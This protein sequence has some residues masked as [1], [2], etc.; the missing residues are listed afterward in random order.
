MKAFSKSFTQQEPLPEASILRAT[1]IMRNGRLH[2]YNVMPGEVSETS[3]LEQEFARYQ[4]VQYCLACAS[5]GYAM[6]TALRAFGIEA[7]EPILTNAWTLSPVPGAID[8]AGGRPVLVETT[9]QLVLNLED[10]ENKL[11]GTSSRLLLLSHMRGHVVD[12][13]ALVEIL[14]R[15][16]AAL[17]E[18]CAHTM[19][20][21]WNSKKIGTFGVAACFSTQTYKHIN[22]GEGGLL[23]TNDPELM[24]R[25]VMLSGS[26]ML[27]G[28]HLAGPSEQ[29][30]SSIRLTT[31]NCSGRMDNLR[32]AIL[33]PQLADLDKQVARWLER[34][35]AIEIEL[36]GVKG[37]SV[38]ARPHK[39]H[40]V[41][42]SFQ[43]VI[44][45]ITDSQ[46]E[47]FLTQC[48]EHGVDV[49]WFGAKE[50][51][52]YTSHYSSWH[53]V[54]S[55]P[56]ISTD[57]ILHDLFDVRIPL[58]FSPEDCRHIGR[59]IGLCCGSSMSL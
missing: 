7:G 3:I 27:Y 43:F 58:T 47:A 39:E 41:G 59:L 15:H 44:P 17:I 18:D 32:A 55:A 31:P 19:G 11:Q 34:Y 49:K 16:G 38:I 42:S 56:L 45:G 28:Q 30:Y 21:A 23:T 40:F 8:A 26:Y 29:T 2:R 12:M 48:K 46:A 20:A 51:H 53:Y 6:T 35:R 50:P 14:H 33:R 54:D 24:A 5:C 13:D 52:G 22:S 36:T 10:L 57:Q 25:A 4:G 37:L 1:E 9:E